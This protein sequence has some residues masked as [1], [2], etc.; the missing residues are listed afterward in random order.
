[1]SISRGADPLF[2]WLSADGHDSATRVLPLSDGSRHFNL[3]DLALAEHGIV[4]QGFSDAPMTHSADGGN[5]AARTF[6]AL[7]IRL[8][9]P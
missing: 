5:E 9:Q 1:M 4:A 2:A 8:A 7:R 3:H 6:G